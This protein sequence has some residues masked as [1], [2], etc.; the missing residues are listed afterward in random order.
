MH[1]IPFFYSLHIYIYNI[2][3]PTKDAFRVFFS[4]DMRGTSRWDKMRDQVKEAV[5][6]DFSSLAQEYQNLLSRRNS[7]RF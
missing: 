5:Q 6:S 4:G 3:Q 7:I 2:K 1:Y